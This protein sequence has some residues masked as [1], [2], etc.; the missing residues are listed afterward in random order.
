ME[1]IPG[2]F[3]TTGSDFTLDLRPFKDGGRQDLSYAQGL[4]SVMAQRGGQ[5]LVLVSDTGTILG[6]SGAERFVARRD[7]CG[8]RWRALWPRESR[9]LVQG[10]LQTA[11]A[12]QREV[13]IELSR[14]SDARSAQYWEAILSPLP[15]DPLGDAGARAPAVLIT[16]RDITAAKGV[17]HLKTRLVQRRK[18]DPVSN[19]G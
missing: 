12:E 1:D 18:Q 6:A 9:P 14:M 15:A 11:V 3:S 17:A 4:L 8:V 2:N 10:A 5:C 19:R 13:T 7:L 16:L